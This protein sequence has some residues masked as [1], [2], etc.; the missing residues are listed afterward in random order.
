MITAVTSGKKGGNGTFGE[1]SRIWPTP[2]YPPNENGGEQISSGR[3]FIKGG[4]GGGTILGGLT[5][6][7]QNTHGPNS[8]RRRVLVLEKKICLP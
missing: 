2:M 3:D 8:S 4:I 7:D 5:P 1:P 6:S